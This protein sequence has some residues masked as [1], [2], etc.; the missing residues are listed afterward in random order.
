M[1][2]TRTLSGILTLAVLLTLSGTA[3]AHDD[4][5]HEKG[6]EYKEHHMKEG[7]DTYESGHPEGHEY[8]KGHA[9]KTEGSDGEQAGGEYRDH[10]GEYKDHHGEY[11]EGHHDR[12]SEG[13]DNMQDSHH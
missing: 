1:Q 4:A 5:H 7:S 11:K 12:K 9:Y 3:L 10:H 6:G 8:R 2:R 13:S